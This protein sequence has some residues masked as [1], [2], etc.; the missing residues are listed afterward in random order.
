MSATS[1][2][3]ILVSGL[4]ALFATV[5]AAFAEPYAP[6]AKD[7]GKPTIEG[8]ELGYQLERMVLQETAKNMPER[9]AVKQP[10]YP[11]AVVVNARRAAK[12]SHNGVAYTVLPN[13]ILHTTDDVAIVMAFYVE[14]LPGW[15]EYE[16]FDMHYLYEG[17]G[18]FKPMDTSGYRTPHVVVNKLHSAMKYHAIPDAV[19]EITIY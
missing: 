7:P 15:T 9:S 4:L 1:L 18:E 16:E 10:P 17:S 11:G 14:A 2:R 6:I 3:K 5:G 8:E 12:G 19:T 13:V